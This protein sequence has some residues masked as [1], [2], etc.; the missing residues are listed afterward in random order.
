MFKIAVPNSFGGRCL[1]ALPERTEID[2][3]LFLGDRNWTSEMHGEKPSFLKTFV[4]MHFTTFPPSCDKHRR[5]VAVFKNF[6]CAPTLWQRVGRSKRKKKKQEAQKE[7]EHVQ[8]L[9][10]S[11]PAARSRECAGKRD[12]GRAL[13][14]LNQFH[15]QTQ[16]AATLQT[17]FSFVNSLLHCVRFLCR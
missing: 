3:M 15:S 16:L 6:P 11:N 2:K 5:Q 1:A 13:C 4:I 17:K 9:H 7:N 8:L 14:L 12:V 10:L